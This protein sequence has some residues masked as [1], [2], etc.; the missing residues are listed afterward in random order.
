MK[1]KAKKPVHSEEVRAN[2]RQLL[3]RDVRL[4]GFGYDSAAGIAFVLAQAL[5]LDGSVLEIG[6]GKGRF[7][8]K[9]A[10]HVTTV[11]TVDISAEEQACARLEAER[12]ACERPSTNHSTPSNR[13]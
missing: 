1:T 3:E 7:L 2:H 10:P 5:P 8:V 12:A 6:T 9:L 13:R 4:H 11:T